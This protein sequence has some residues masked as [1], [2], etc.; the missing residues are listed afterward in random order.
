[1]KLSNLSIALRLNVILGGMVALM[2]S[3]LGVYSY[4]VHVARTE[5]VE[6]TL[7]KLKLVSMANSLTANY[8]DVD[9]VR[10]LSLHD[11]GFKGI[12]GLVASFSDDGS[13]PMVFTKNGELLVS[14]AGIDV[15]PHI[16][17]ILTNTQ[18]NGFVTD[19]VILRENWILAK[20]IPSLELFVAV[21][22]NEVLLRS[23]IRRQLFLVVTA[24]LVAIPLFLVALFVLNNDVV[25]GI[26]KAV[27]F[28]RSV[29]EGNL[30][31]Q[32]VVDRKDEIGQLLM[33]LNHMSSRIKSVVSKVMQGADTI[34]SLSE[35]LSEASRQV[36]EG[37]NVQASA[38]EE[39]SS[40]MEE[41]GA[42][43]HQ[44]SENALVTDKSVKEMADSME[45][46]AELSL[47]TEQ[48]M[49]TVTKKINVISDIAR[50][51]NLLALN[52]AVEAA[53]A[54]AHGRGFAVVAAEVKKLAERS[55][56]D[57]DEILKV[58]ARGYEY[59]RQ[60][61]IQL[62]EVMP[63]LHES[64]SRVTEIVSSSREQ[65]VGA[66][67]VNTALVE[68]NRITQQNASAS[69]QVTLGTSQMNRIAAEMQQEISFF[70]V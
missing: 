46:G 62:N 45:K 25:K 38:A 41:M 11:A 3:G 19:D 26:R 37:S 47:Q 9:A 49:L 60:T 28:A 29:E 66:D 6:L 65:T 52:A 24:L 69:E 2:V 7:S 39:V 55:K 14:K 35:R 70:K 20:Y 10:K 54:G 63:K 48:I 17:A 34:T 42:N 33:S 40:S 36:S 56:V 27:A 22:S 15:S 58:V 50:Q 57:S 16:K 31:Q 21:K 51:T 53:Q 67:Q 5:N 44:N 23:Q 8:K 61:G 13:M 64:T 59:T 1:M 12:E 30:Q 4:Q 43:I 68:L 32:L 18:V